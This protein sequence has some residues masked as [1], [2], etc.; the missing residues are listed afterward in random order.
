MKTGFAEIN[1]TSLYYETKGEGQPLLMVHGYPLDSS[2]WDAQFEEFA[3]HFQVIRFDSAGS[4]QSRAHD[5]D[6]S[7]VDDIKG[8]LEYLG[9]QKVHLIGLSVGG[10][11]SMDFTLAN[12]EMVDKLILVSTGLLGWSEF[13]LER[14]EYQ[15]K[16]KECPQSDGLTEVV[17]LMC[18]AWAAGPFR[19]V[20]ELSQDFIEKYS[21]MLRTNLTKENGKGKMILPETKTIDV[22]ENIKVPTLIVSPDVD[23]PEFSAISQFLHEKIRASKM[24]VIPGTAHMINM[25]KPS[26]FN[27]L[28]L[29]FLK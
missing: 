4:G 22:A 26:E 1:G 27:R 12:P 19:S 23:F 29:S 18:K 24:A 10:N 14:Q 17:N 11:L 20:D 21:I 7:L 3:K 28:V 13:S 6:F 9:V 16:L 25:E 2:M 5:N 15:A 8:L